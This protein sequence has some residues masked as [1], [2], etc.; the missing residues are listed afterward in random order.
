M[1]RAPTSKGM[2]NGW[3]KFLPMTIQFPIGLQHS[4][5]RRSSK[6]EIRFG[7][8]PRKAPFIQRLNKSMEPTAGQ[9]LLVILSSRTR[10]MQST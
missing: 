3:E 9:A 4:L 5:L 10:P 1:M 2:D 6:L 8:K 7:C